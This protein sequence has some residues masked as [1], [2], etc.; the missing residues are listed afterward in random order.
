MKDIAWNLSLVISFPLMKSLLHFT[1]TPG[2]PGNSLQDTK[3]ANETFA[4]S[5][6]DRIG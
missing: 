3:E 2:A 1:S 6:E 5:E 4:L